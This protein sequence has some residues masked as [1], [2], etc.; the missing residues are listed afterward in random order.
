MF[1]DGYS[2][3]GIANLQEVKQKWPETAVQINKKHQILE[4]L[5]L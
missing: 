4:A 3:A 2:Y 1:L 5:T